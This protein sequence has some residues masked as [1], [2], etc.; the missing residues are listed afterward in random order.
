MLPQPQQPDLPIKER[1]VFFVYP[2]DFSSLHVML[3]Y[4]I[5]DCSNKVFNG[6]FMFNSLKCYEMIM[7]LQKLLLMPV[8][9]CFLKSFLNKSCH[10]AHN[11]AQ[12]GYK[13]IH[14]AYYKQ[15]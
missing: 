10:S 11:N 1:C 12:I 14:M 7:S 3:Q 15:W 9:F 2:S 13:K 5:S 6:H 8:I 4:L